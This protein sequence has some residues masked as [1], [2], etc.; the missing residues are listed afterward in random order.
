MTHVNI[1]YQSQ[2]VALVIWYISI[3][4]YKFQRINSVSEQE[5]IIFDTV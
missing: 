3:F 2:A 5:K 4:L 1:L